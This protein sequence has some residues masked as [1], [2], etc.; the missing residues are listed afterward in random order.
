M[1]QDLD[2]WFRSL[3]QR[4]FYVALSQEELPY[5]FILDKEFVFVEFQI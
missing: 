5:F 3:F 4:F 2:S 1:N